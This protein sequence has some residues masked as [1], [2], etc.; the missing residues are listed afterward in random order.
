MRHLLLV[1]MIALLPLRGWAGDVM[2]VRMA[3][4][5]AVSSQAMEH[6]AMGEDPE[7]QVATEHAAC[8]G[9]EAQADT[10]TGQGH[11]TAC[12]VCPLCHTLALDSGAMAFPVTPAATLPR[13]AAQG[14]ADAAR[15]PGFKPPIA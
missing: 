8:A 10:G 13:F 6:P 14:H 7:S 2:A 9:H 3:A 4:D 5:M 15:A 1:L 11:C 12:V